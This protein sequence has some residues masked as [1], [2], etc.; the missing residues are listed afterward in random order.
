MNK[1][2]HLPNKNISSPKL[3]SASLQVVT[4]SPG[5]N[6]SQR[7]LQETHRAGDEIHLQVRSSNSQLRATCPET[8]VETSFTPGVRQI[9]PSIARKYFLKAKAVKVN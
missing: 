4:E 5:H 9:N 2:L 7:Q 6:H 8:T 3:L 1:S